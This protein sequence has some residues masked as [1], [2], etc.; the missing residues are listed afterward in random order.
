MRDKP[1]TRSF[2]KTFQKCETRLIDMR[3]YLRRFQNKVFLTFS[4]K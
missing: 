3:K 2:E 4:Q 1:K